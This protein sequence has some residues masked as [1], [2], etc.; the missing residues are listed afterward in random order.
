MFSFQMAGQEFLLTKDCS[1]EVASVLRVV[2]V[3]HVLD[4][5]L[6]IFRRVIT[7]VAMEGLSSVRVYA[8][9]VSLMSYEI[10]FVFGGIIT[11][12][13]LIGFSAVSVTPMTP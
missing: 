11:K 2:V 9:H 4:K 13:A 5:I 10:L 12:V 8:V 7:K 3:S 6:F 1:A